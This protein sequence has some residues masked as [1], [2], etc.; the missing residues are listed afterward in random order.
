MVAFVCLASG[1]GR[2]WSVRGRRMNIN[3]VIGRHQTIIFISTRSDRYLE[4]LPFKRHKP[5]TWDNERI[6]LQRTML[7]S[8]APPR[9]L[10]G[11][12]IDFI[13]TQC[14]PCKHSCLYTT[15]KQTD[16]PA[17]FYYNTKD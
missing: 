7:M 9:G 6:D 10:S 12:L 16:G 1:R 5:R 14:V 11:K 8:A 15:D 4:I 13:A 17:E 2:R 3:A